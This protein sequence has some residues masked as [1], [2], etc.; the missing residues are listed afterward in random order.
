MRILVLHLSDLHIKNDGNPILTRAKEIVNAV[1]N[2]DYNVEVAFIFF[3][4]DIAFSGTPD[5]Y[6]A[7]LKF[8][9]ELQASIGEHLT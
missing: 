3:T 9:D 5:Q 2:M 1:K 7:A 8:L 6:E 4:G